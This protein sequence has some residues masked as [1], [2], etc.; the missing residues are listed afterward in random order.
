ML[1]W[2]LKGLSRHV[3]SFK[4]YLINIRTFYTKEKDDRITTQ[5]KSVTFIPKSIHISSA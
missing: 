5:N 1:W 2:L 4:E 3:L